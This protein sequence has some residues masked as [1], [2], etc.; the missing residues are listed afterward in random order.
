MIWTWRCITWFWVVDLLRQQSQIP[1]VGLEMGVHGA[2]ARRE[3]VCGLHE[4]VQLRAVFL[5]LLEL[6]ADFRDL[7]KKK[8][9]YLNCTAGITKR[10]L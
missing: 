9:R 3:L 1:L 4:L 6:P 7:V 2:V 5:Q 10:W 8:R